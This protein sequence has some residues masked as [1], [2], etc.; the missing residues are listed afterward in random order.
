[1]AAPH[2]VDPV[3]LLEKHLAS[4]SPDVLREMIAAFANAMM[5]ASADQVCGAGYGQRSD[6]RVSAK[7]GPI[8]PKNA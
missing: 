2:S 3:Q 5:S 1:M 7:S 8:I 4:A 6:Q